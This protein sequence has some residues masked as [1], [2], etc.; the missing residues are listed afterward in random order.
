MVCNETP[1]AGLNAPGTS[2]RSLFALSV[3]NPPA[4]PAGSSR[5]IVERP[6][7]GLAQG[8]YA[9][10]AWGIAVAGLVVVALAVVY[11]VMRARAI[12]RQ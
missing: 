2:M 4:A 11:L 1:A 10:P 5:M 7:T 6:P 8:T 9:W 12:G 3:G